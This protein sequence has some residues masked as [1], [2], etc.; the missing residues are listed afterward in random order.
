[1]FGLVALILGAPVVLEYLD[2]G[3]V[4]RFPTAILASSIGLVAIL[5]LV[6]GYV[7]DAVGRSRQEAA[8]LSYLNHP[9]PSASVAESRLAV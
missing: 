7:L 9:A 2:T 6:L 4:P 1:M 5:M 3:L 8:Q